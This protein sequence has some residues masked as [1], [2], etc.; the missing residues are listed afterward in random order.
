MST[1][2][3]KGAPEFTFF[4]PCLNEAPRIAGT[5]DTLSSAMKELGRTYEVLVVDDGSADDTSAV[6]EAYIREH[7]ECDIHLH[8][9]PVNFG[10]AYSFVEAAFRG[11]GQYY[12]LIWGDNVEP[13][14]TLLA[15]LSKAGTAD[16]IIPYYPHVP[17]KSRIRMQLS[18]FYTWLVN[19]IGGFQLHYY[20]GSVL[21]SR[22]VA[23]RWS[24]HNHG[25]TGF[26]ADLI[27]QILA[28]GAT[29]VEVP[30]LGHHVN[31]DSKNT[32]ISFHNIVSTGLTLLAIFSRRLSYRICRNKLTRLQGSRL[33]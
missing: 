31:K 13:K 1:A 28:E 27:T 10:V 7:A 24:P 15:I 26:L 33:P 30:V 16:L 5:L 3:A 11:R 4:V 2:S 19:S 20:N 14:E 12:R 6:V 29:Y 32:P 9:N 17:G 21:C 25:F 18:G 22:Y 23:M 8:S